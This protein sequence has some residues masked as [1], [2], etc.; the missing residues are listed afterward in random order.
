MVISGSGSQNESAYASTSSLKSLP[1]SIPSSLYLLITS[2]AAMLF[3][4]IL[5]A[6]PATTSLVKSA[7]Y[8]DGE[9]YISI[10]PSL[11]PRSM[12]PAK[13]GFMIKICSTWLFSSIF[14]AF[15]LSVITRSIPSLPVSLS[16]SNDELMLRSSST[17]ATGIVFSFSYLSA[18]P[19]ETVISRGIIIIAAKNS[20]SAS[21]IFNL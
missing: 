4:I 20:L 1:I 15:S 6:S 5:I 13:P 3:I 16:I 14:S 8:D 9:L 12:D 21:I 10:R 17:M 7:E 11:S 19:A 2:L 18:Y